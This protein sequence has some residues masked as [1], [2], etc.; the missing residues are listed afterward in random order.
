MQ[1]FESRNVFGRPLEPCGT[2]P[3]TGFY[4]DGDCATGHDDQGIHTVCAEMT[5]DFLE[6]SRARGND[7][8]TPNPAFG[9]PGLKAGDRWCLCA[10]RWLE[11]YKA[12]CAPGVFLRATHEET[13]A[14][15]P[16]DLLA[17]HA[18]D[19]AE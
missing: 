4:R 10:G 16:R 1:R 2:D 7:L 17:E 8:S 11:A 5:E 13:L 19:T 14:I 3:V 9:F 12:G 18:R 15:I 6:Y